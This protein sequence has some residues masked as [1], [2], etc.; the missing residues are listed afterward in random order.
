MADFT[1]TVLNQLNMLGGEPPTLWGT[2][3]WGTD[4][5]GHNNDLVVEIGKVLSLSLSLS[6]TWEKAFTLD[7]ESSLSLSSAMPD[8]TLVDAAGFYHVFRG[9]V[10]D[11]DDSVASDYTEVSA[12]GTSWT[13]ASEAS[14]SWS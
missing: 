12:S 8:R 5:W 7:V 11:A 9:N 3:E 14:T 1:Q 6:E 13:A 4:N 2:M 10:T